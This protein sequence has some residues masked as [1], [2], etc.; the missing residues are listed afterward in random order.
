ML[1][2]KFD[3]LIGDMNTYLFLKSDFQK[4]CKS[5]FSVRY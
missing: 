3:H 1:R 2:Q 4:F 5:E